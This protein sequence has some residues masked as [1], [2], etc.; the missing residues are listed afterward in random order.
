[1]VASAWAQ[2]FSFGLRGGVPVSNLADADRGL[3]AETDRYVVGP[4]VEIVF[5]RS[6]AVSVDLLYQR[7][8]FGVS[9]PAAPAA[10]A[11][12][13]QLPILLRRGFS[14]RARP[15]VG[16]GMVFNRFFT[17]EGAMECARGPFGEQFYCIGGTSVAELR[18]RGTHG[19]VVSS[20]L[21]FRAKF[22][23]LEPEVRVAHWA[24]RNFGVSGSPLRSNLTE[25]EALV[26]VRFEV[27]R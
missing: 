1:M 9:T 27:D 17:V 14:V 19:F 18:H 15:F 20:G 23:C 10:T 26:G 16:A 11:H 13:L 22:V 25:A 5:P 12:R 8:R 6:W 3:K 24:D 4:T 7:A 2:T 21:Q